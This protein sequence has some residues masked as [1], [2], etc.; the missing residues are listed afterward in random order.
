M[1]AIV[2]VDPDLLTVGQEKA[3]SVSHSDTQVKNRRAAGAKNDCLVQELV[4]G[5]EIELE[6]GR[7]FG[8]RRREFL[9]RLFE[10]RCVGLNLSANETD[11]HDVGALFGGN[12]QT[13][14]MLLQ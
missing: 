4:V 6:A 11:L 2:E 10:G 9:L 5:I 13:D 3:L 8:P 1:L 12:R 7:I 14:L